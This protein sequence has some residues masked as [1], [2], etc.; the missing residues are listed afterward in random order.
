[1]HAPPSCEA[2]KKG[3]RNPECMT[4]QSEGFG[5]VSFQGR[6]RKQAAPLTWPWCRE[7]DFNAMTRDQTQFWR[8]MRRHLVLSG[9]LVVHRQ[10]YKYIE[11]RLGLVWRRKLTEVWCQLSAL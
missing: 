2:S 11:Q 7:L 3:Q 8:L 6:T 1:M 4:V 9:L 5:N 10:T